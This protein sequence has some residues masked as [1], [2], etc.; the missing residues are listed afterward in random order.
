MGMG[1]HYR[2]SYET[3]LVG[4]KPGAACFWFDDTKRIENIIRPGDYG[5]KKIIPDSS[6]HPTVKP[7]A[8]AA[9]FI[10]LHSQPENLILDPFIGSGTTL[11]AAQNEGRQAVGIELNEEYCKMAVE[12]LRQQSF[13]SFAHNNSQA[14]QKPI[15]QPNLFEVRTVDDE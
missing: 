3:I 10:R 13:F 1:W 4:V 8:L 7:V 5:I 11:V 12:R 2:R 14:A 15:D 6:M 9:H